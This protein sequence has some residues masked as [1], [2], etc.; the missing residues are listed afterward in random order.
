MKIESL[1]PL[2]FV[3][4]IE[5]CLP[6]WIER[7]GFAIYAE[8]KK[9][10]RYGF[11]L[12]GKDGAALMYQSHA[13]LAEDL[14]QLDARDRATSAT[15]YFRVDDLDAVEAAMAGVPLVQERRTTFYGAKEI[16]VREPAGNVVIFS[17]HA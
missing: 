10:G 11:V 7:L 16:G 6:F 14:P 4:E 1:A 13:S 8:V 15:L 3:P 12:L 17:Q 5:P 9:D 2:L